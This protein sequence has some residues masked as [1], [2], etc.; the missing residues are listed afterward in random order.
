MI[1]RCDACWE[2]FRHS[3]DFPAWLDRCRDVY[4][5]DLAGFSGPGI[6]REL[7]T[8]RAYEWPGVQTYTQH[9]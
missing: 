6:E 9:G 7:T 5:F 8:Y 2:A 4:S 3:S 1:C